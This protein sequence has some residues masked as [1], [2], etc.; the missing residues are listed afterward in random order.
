MLFV[1]IFIAFQLG[2]ISAP[3]LA[4]EVGDEAYL[5]LRDELNPNWPE[6]FAFKI[7]VLA[8]PERGRFMVEIVDSYPPTGRVNAENLPVTGDQA[9]VSRKMMF[10][11]Q[12]AGVRPGKR[13]DGK[14]VCAR[15]MK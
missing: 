13:F 14:P 1:R 8:P 11:K 7:K 5:C 3:V 15:L 6:K 2:F 12:Q 4:F 9:R 10:S